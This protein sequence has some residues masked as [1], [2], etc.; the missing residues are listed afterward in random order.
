M[1]QKH[2]AL[3][4]QGLLQLGGEPFQYS[5]GA[6]GSAGAALVKRLQ[7]QK[8][9]AFVRCAVTEGAAGV[10]VAGA[11]EWLAGHGLLQLLHGGLGAGQGGPIRQLQHTSEL[12]HILLGDESGG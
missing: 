5:F 3:A 2:A 1:A 11:D 8:E 6:V 9:D 10:K 12:T 7:P 4:S